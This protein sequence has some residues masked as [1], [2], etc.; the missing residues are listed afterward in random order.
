MPLSHARSSSTFIRSPPLSPQSPAYVLTPSMSSLEPPVET[1]GRWV[2]RLLFQGV[3][4]YGWFVCSL[5]SLKWLSAHA[6]TDNWQACKVC[7]QHAKPFAMWLHS[8]PRDDSVQARLARA[9]P[10]D[11]ALCGEC[12]KQGFPCWLDSSR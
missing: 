8:G 10:H 3:S 1:E 12:T 5:C 9:T 6:R 7:K 2:P 11:Q 4:S